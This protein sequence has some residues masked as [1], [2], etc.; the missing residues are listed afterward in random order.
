M[1]N[2]IERGNGV[3]AKNAKTIIKN[4]GLKQTVIATKAGLSVQMLNDMLNGR[5]IMKAVDIQ[6]IANALQISVNELFGIKDKSQD[7]VG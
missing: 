5:R 4:R 2:N 6:A 7:K 3:V 1:M